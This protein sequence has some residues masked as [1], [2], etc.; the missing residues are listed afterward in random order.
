MFDKIRVSSLAVTLGAALLA[1][2]ALPQLKA[3]ESD[4]KTIVSFNTPVE[5]TGQVLP[6]GT[7]VFKTLGDVEND[8]VTVTNQDESH[9]YG[10]FRAIPIE[11]STVSGKARVELSEGPGNAPEAVRAWFYPGVN[12]G[13][14][15]PA[16]KAEK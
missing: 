7:Y 15:F 16:A 10:I 14:E 5:I 8:I 6:A 13:W 1:A 4:K 9:L 11:T 12:Y 3:S 2:T